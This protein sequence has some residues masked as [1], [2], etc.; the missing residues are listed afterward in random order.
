MNCPHDRSVM[1]SLEL[2]EVEID[3]CT[4]CSGIWLDS[5]ELELI[6]GESEAIREFL[7]SFSISE[8]PREKKLKC[9]I[10]DKPMDKV[11]C[12]DE[13]KVMVDRCPKGDG[14]W[15][16][17]GELLDVV[18]AGNLA[19]SAETIDLIRDMLKDSLER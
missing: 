8:S 3:Y 12:D 19:G 18:E 2:N 16:D 13:G 6:L 7:A 1:I 9:P 4:K 15:F 10:C 5:G 11:I 14:L 17:K